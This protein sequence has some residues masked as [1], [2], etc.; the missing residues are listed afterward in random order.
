[1]KKKRDD[2][3]RPML[4]VW[5]ESD[6]SRRALIN[7]LTVDRINGLVSIAFYKKN[8]STITRTKVSKRM[9]NSII[10]LLEAMV[11]ACSSDRTKTVVRQD[12]LSKI[13]KVDQRTVGRQITIAKQ[14]GVIDLVARFHPEFGFQQSNDCRV[15]WEQIKTI[16]SES[17]EKVDLSNES[18]APA[19][20]RGG[21]DITSGRGR[22][23][24]GVAP[25]LRRGGVG[26]TSGL[27]S[28]YI[29]LD[30]R[31]STFEEEEINFSD[32][33]KVKTALVD[34]GVEL[35][36]PAIRQSQNKPDPPSAELLL[37]IVD[38]YNARSG[39]DPGFLKRKIENAT[40][41]SNPANGWP[42]SSRKRT[43]IR[44][45]TATERRDKI[46]FKL[47]SFGNRDIRAD[48][49]DW[50]LFDWIESNV[51]RALADGESIESVVDKSK[52]IFYE[53]QND[54]IATT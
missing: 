40:A 2:S 47:R 31:E 21:P 14:I 41:V 19:L 38:E 32:F 43:P 39:V 7:S 29:N 24:V 52:T 4:A 48:G 49:I 3:P 6:K 8:A 45:P 37:E 30:Q 5:D 42:Q 9:V 13:L 53:L 33:E 18:R 20:R 25:A 44:A 36:E 15:N 16:V 34:A 51:D 12:S 17:A 28:T 1:M 10:R 22:H 11:F 27:V 26:M 50:K 35:A 23:D 54:H 46:V